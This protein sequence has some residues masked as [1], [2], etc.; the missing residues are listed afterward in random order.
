MMMKAD[1]QLTLIIF[2]HPLILSAIGIEPLT[3]ILTLVGFTDFAAENLCF[4]DRAGGFVF[5]LVQGRI[6]T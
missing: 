5:L 6:I 2:G 1:R 3:L 4:L